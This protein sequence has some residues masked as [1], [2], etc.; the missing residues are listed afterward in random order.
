[1]DNSTKVKEKEEAMKAVKRVI[2]ATRMSTSQI[3]KKIGASE[4]SVNRWITGKCAP[5]L[6]YFI[7]M[8]NI[9][10]DEVKE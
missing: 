5:S 9:N 7:K 3:S 10:S 2:A 6:H 8:I 1:M 4:K